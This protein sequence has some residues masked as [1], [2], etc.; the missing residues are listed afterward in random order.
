VASTQDKKIRKYLL[1]NIAKNIDS[2]GFNERELID[3]LE[4]IAEHE[5]AAICDKD[6]HSINLFRGMLKIFEFLNCSRM[7]LHM[8]GLYI[9]L[10]KKGFKIT[11][12]QNR[13]GMQL[14]AVIAA[15]KAGTGSIDS[16]DVLLWAKD[17]QVSE[18]GLKELNNLADFVTKEFGKNNLVEEGIFVNDQVEIIAVPTIIIDKPLTLVGMGDTISS[19]SLVGAR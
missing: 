1:D 7:Q 2:V 5:L 9:T 4:V 6:T 19:I 15:A 17:R 10:Q 8:F 18:V 12:I 3:I 13:N 11:A 16:A 14:A